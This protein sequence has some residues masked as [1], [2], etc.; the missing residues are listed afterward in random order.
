LKQR[1]RDLFE[2]EKAAYQSLQKQIAQTEKEIDTQVYAL[3]EWTAAEIQ[4][5]ENQ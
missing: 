1:K 3:Y 4:I 2:A 5:I